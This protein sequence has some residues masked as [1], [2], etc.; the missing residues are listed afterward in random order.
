MNQSPLKKSMM[1]CMCAALC[2]VLPQ[3][4]R[5]IPGTDGVYGLIRMPVLL[6]TFAC[7]MGSGFVCALL[8][9]LLS[10]VVAGLPTAVMLPVILVECFAASLVLALMKKLLSFRKVSAD[11]SLCFAVVIPAG[12]LV[13]GCISALLF[14]G[15]SL[16]PYFWTGGYFLISLPGMLIE[17]V[18]LP[19]VVNALIRAGLIEVCRPAAPADGAE[20]S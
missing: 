3:A 1:A 11:V 17:M 4:L 2:I 7:G 9:L 8:G 15:E 20:K 12:R 10:L 18:L 13:G 5:V 16:V 19:I 14:A 6:C